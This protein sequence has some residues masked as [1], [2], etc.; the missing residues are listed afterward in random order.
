M[1]GESSERYGMKGPRVGNTLLL[2]ILGSGSR[3]YGLPPIR[4]SQSVHRRWIYRRRAIAIVAI[5]RPWTWTM[6]MTMAGGGIF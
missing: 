4:E 5:Y 1:M 2:E 6:T 3:V